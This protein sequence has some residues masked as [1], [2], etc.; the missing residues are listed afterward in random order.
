M[1]VP[2]TGGYAVATVTRPASAWWEQP[3]P[4]AIAALMS[5]GVGCWVAVQPGRSQ[6]LQQLLT[7][8]RTWDFG[9]TNPFVVSGLRVDYPPHTFVMFGPLQ[10]LP[11]V[12]APSVFVVLNVVM[13]ALAAC[14]LGVSPSERKLRYLYSTSILRRY[15]C[16]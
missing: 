8:L 15:I 5:V 12:I 1:R 2:S 13:C 3:V 11:E 7:W 10:W 4:W 16:I 6:D 14:R 9:T